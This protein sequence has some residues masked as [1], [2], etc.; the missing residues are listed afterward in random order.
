M[1]PATKM[2]L[3]TVAYSLLHSALAARQTKEWIA[4]K[5][6]PEPVQAWYR[7]FF[8]GQSMVT[9]AALLGYGAHL[10]RQVLY[11]LRPP[12]SWICRVGQAG[13]IVF[14]LAAMRQVGFAR[15]TGIANLQDG[16]RGQPSLPAPVAQGP[17]RDQ[18]GHLSIGGPF[19]W[20]RH[21]LNFGPLPLFWLVPTMTTRRLAFNL[22]ST[23][24]FIVGSLHEE[25]RLRKAYGPYYIGYMRSCVPFFLPASPAVHSKRSTNRR[26]A[27]KSKIS[28]EQKFNWAKK[29]FVQ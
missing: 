28:R 22:V 25:S 19:R 3:A 15:L 21:P 12:L 13:G 27:D 6:G 16:K 4:R 17:E 1:G 11:R 7:I 29:K 20:S 18:T 8:V 5:V 10:P 26:L 24:Y 14:M 2:A 23:A 9:T